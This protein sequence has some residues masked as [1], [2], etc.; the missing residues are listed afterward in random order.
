VPDA[1]VRL[2]AAGALRP[3]SKLTP[4]AVDAFV[5]QARAAAGA[6]QPSTVSRHEITTLYNQLYLEPR[7]PDGGAPYFEDPAT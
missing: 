6:V 3:Q 7:T 1:L 2:I 4:P 5:T